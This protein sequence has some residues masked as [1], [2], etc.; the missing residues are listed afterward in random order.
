ML[1][2]YAP[3]GTKTNNDDDDDDDDELKST[4]LPQLPAFAV[5]KFREFCLTPNLTFIPKTWTLK[6]RP[7]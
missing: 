2:A 6:Q 4:Q 7:N 1:L 5:A 3:T